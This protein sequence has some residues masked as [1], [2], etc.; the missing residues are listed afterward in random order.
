M[1]CLKIYPKLY[2][3][4]YNNQANINYVLKNYFLYLHVWRNGRVVECG[5][6]ENR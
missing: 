3:A 5:G 2:Y 6:L 4:K 1:V